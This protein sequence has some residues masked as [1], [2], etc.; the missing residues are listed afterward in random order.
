MAFTYMKRNDHLR[1]ISCIAFRFSGTQKM[2]SDW[3]QYLSKFWM[4]FK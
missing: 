4:A 1:A 2:T 3:T